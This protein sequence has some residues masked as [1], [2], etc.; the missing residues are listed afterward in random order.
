[1]VVNIGLIGV[2]GLG[3]L[4][5]K[6]FADL[7]G[8][9]LVAGV[10]VS[11]EARELCEEQFGIPTYE[12][13][14]RML[15]ERG[16]GIDAVSIVT[17]HTLH[18]EQARACLDRGLHVLVEKPMVTRVAHAKDLVRRADEGDLVL[19]VGYQRHF[20]PAYREIRRI[21]RDGRIGELHTLNCFLGQDW[22]GP[23]R[24]TWR[25]DRSLS[26]GG[27]LYDSGSHL[28][29]AMLWTTSGIPDTV[30][31]QMRFEEPRID[32]D[33]ALT[34]RLDREDTSVL[35]SVGIT[36]DGA[37]V[38]PTEGYTYWGDGGRLT[39]AEGRITVTEK[40][41]ATYQTELDAASD[42]QTL[43]RR[44]IANFVESVAGTAEPAVPGTFALEVTA[45][46]EAA[47]RAAERGTHV[48]VR[49]LVDG[50]SDHADGDD[51]AGAE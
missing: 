43:N 19:Q 24:D 29:D 21:L 27:Q 51:A 42:F 44:K 22:I 6:T 7:E 36:G 49:S 38:A 40:G 37:D 28:I 13:Y 18:Y 4:Q 3:Y 12:E 32:V 33:S 2:G 9:R 11:A 16:D 30:T 26:G 8:C 31:A 41:A 10:D 45:L 5:A 14:P 23:Q 35:A 48:D 34:I 47:Y 17:P 15:D 39:Y 1:M 50:D 20:H 46:T 25:T